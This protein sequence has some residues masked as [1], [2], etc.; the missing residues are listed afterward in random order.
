MTSSKWREKRALYDKLIQNNL[1]LTNFS[2]KKIQ[3]KRSEP[4]LIFLT[5]IEME[6]SRPRN[7]AGY[8]DHLDK[9]RLIQ[10]FMIWSTRFDNIIVIRFIDF[11]FDRQITTKMAWSSSKNFWQWWPETTSQMTKKRSFWTRSGHKYIFN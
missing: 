2:W 9:I 11:I 1:F 8:S 4:F 3:L 6:R 5:K 7:S 10:S